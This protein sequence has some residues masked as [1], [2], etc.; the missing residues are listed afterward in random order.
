M[1]KTLCSVVS[2]QLVAGVLTIA[3]KKN[4]IILKSCKIEAG[5]VVLVALFCVLCNINF[6]SIFYKR[7][8]CTLLQ[9]SEEG[10]VKIT[11]E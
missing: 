2:G 11:A 3:N 6:S 1:F 9:V 8:Q 7:A 5:I 4:E 10:V